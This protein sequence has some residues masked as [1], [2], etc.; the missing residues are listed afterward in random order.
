MTQNQAAPDAPEPASGLLSSPTYRSPRA[1]VVLIL[2]LVIGLAADL[3]SK[4]WAFNTLAPYPIQIDREAVLAGRH[5]ALI[6]SHEPTVVLPSVLEFKLVL[7]V[8]AVFGAG[9]GKRPLF[10]GV[11]IFAVVFGLF[12]FGWWTSPRDRWAHV[13]IGLLLAGGLGNLYDRVLYACVRDFIHPFPGVRL[14]FG[15]RYPSNEDQLWPYVSNVADKW[16]LIGIAIL[17]VHAW[18]MGG[19][20]ERMLTQRAQAATPPA[21]PS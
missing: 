8:G 1:W 9:A 15:W 7:N 3:G 20:E 12:L 14:P 4:Y 21:D 13:G 19:Q 11:T 5:D 10:I 18:R 17:L 6:P 2:V 16:L